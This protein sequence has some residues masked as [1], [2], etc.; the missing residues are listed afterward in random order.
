MRLALFH[1]LK[2]CAEQDIDLKEMIENT[3]TEKKD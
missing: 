3:Q 1:F 2:D